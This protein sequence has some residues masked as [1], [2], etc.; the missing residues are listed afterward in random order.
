M[1]SGGSRAKGPPSG[2][3]CHDHTRSAKSK[4]VCGSRRQEL[5][6]EVGHQD[7]G[8]LG[9]LDG[10]VDAKGQVAEFPASILVKQEPSAPWSMAD[11]RDYDIGPRRG[12]RTSVTATEESC[13]KLAGRGSGP[14]RAAFRFSRNK[15]LPFA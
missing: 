11:R 14:G 1:H 9:C 6:E 2:P 13:E 12:L 4:Y 3:G 5:Y 7:G 15:S 10:V 8:A